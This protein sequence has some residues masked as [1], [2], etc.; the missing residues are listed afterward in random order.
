V[1]EGEAIFNGETLETGVYR[2]QEEEPPADAPL[3]GGGQS[4]D[5]TAQT[6]PASLPEP[7]LASAPESASVP[8]QTQQHIVF[9]STKITTTKNSGNTGLASASKGS[10]SI[11]TET[12]QGQQK[13]VLTLTTNLANGYEWKEIGFQMGDDVIR[14]LRTGTGVRFK[15]IGDGE[16]GWYLRFFTS[17]IKTNDGYDGHFEAAIN[18]GSGSI[19]EV[20]IPFTMITQPPWGKRTAF[21]KEN[22]TEF[23]FWRFANDGS[24]FA[25]NSTIKIIDFEVYSEP[26]K[27]PDMRVISYEAGWW[28]SVYSGSQS[29]T[30]ASFVDFNIGKENIEGQQK[31]VLTLEVSHPRASEWINGVFQVHHNLILQKLRNGSGI[32]FKVLLDEGRDTGWH[33]VI[34]TTDTASDSC[35]YETAIKVERGRIIEVDIPYFALTQPD[36]GFQQRFNKSRIS[37][38]LIQ[39]R[40]EQWPAVSGSSK[41]K[42]FDFEIY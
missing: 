39:R 32:K 10:S 8:E 25:E 16:K 14:K 3:T 31:D 4:A 23:S 15:V 29:A 26:V 30:A 36:W 27:Q 6:I 24:R 28:A 35:H 12:I 1:V 11:K 5:E 13:E 21:K 22:I 37:S 38:L 34:P 2:W 9:A 40:A 17:D 33:L 20:D 7:V 18:T 42:I 19:T 41:I